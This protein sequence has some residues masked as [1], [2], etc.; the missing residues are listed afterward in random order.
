VATSEAYA[1]ATPLDANFIAPES[2]S[3]FA[4]AA[5]ARTTGKA[6]MATKVITLTMS[7]RR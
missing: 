4:T 5:V 7:G 3:L 6:T 2:F 1:L